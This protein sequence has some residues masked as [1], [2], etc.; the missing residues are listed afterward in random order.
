[1]KNL[2]I[3]LIISMAFS[4]MAFA[5]V[6]L[7]SSSPAE[8]EVMDVAP[9]KIE[10]VLSQA[11]KIISIKIENTQGEKFSTSALPKG[12]VEKVSVTIPELASGSYVITWRGASK[13]MHAMSGKIKFSIK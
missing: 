3:A 9:K 6:S 2:I 7:V 1:M 13:D 11:A 12:L 10:M 5:H 8:G 4:S